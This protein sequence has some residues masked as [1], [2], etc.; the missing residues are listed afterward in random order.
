MRPVLEP[1]PSEPQPPANPES[2]PEVRRLLLLTLV[3]LSLWFAD[4]RGPMSGE[5]GVRHRRGDPHDAVS[6]G[7]AWVEDLL[8]KPTHARRDLG[9]SRAPGPMRARRR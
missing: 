1:K 8:P 2:Q 7:R 9:S 3:L 4:V 5:D 6:S